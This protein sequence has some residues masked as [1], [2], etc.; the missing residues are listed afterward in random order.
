MV[1]HFLL[2]WSCSAGFAL[3]N[4]KNKTHRNISCEYSLMLCC[5][6]GMRSNKEV[7]LTLQLCWRAQWWDS[8]ITEYSK[9]LLNIKTLQ[10]FVTFFQVFRVWTLWY[11]VLRNSIVETKWPLAS[12]HLWKQDFFSLQKKDFATFSPRLLKKAPTE[13]FIVVQL[14]PC[15]SYLAQQII[16]F[17]HSCI[18]SPRCHTAEEEE[19]Y[20]FSFCFFCVT[21][22]VT[23]SYR[24]NRMWKEE[25]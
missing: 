7:T 10:Q 14:Q 6:L 25:S 13:F 11:V 20:L 21:T 3:W 16:S 8:L 1:E 22:C 4:N 9:K 17:S 18:S 24:T 23:P 5:V 2:K 15:Q 12:A 19:A